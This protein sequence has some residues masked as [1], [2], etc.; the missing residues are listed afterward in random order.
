MASLTVLVGTR[1]VVVSWY[2]PYTFSSCCSFYLIFFFVPIH[3][4]L[5]VVHNRTRWLLVMKVLANKKLRQDVPKHR[6]FKHSLNG[7][8]NYSEKTAKKSGRL[9]AIRPGDT[10]IS[11]LNSSLHESEEYVQP[12]IEIFCCKERHGCP[13]QVLVLWFADA[14]HLYT[15]S[16]YKIFLIFFHGWIPWKEN[17]RKRWVSNQSRDFWHAKQSSWQFCTRRVSKE[18]SR[19]NSFSNIV[20]VSQGGFAPFLTIFLFQISILQ[21]F[22]LLFLRRAETGNETRTGIWIETGSQGTNFPRT[23]PLIRMKRKQT[24]AWSVALTNEPRFRKM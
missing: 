6:L 7:S 10:K 9:E 2:R 5:H 15:S 20:S 14:S 8:S 1:R 23:L 24:G 18:I 4:F 19:L 11:S 3:S 12:E 13:G 22:R 16:S 21:N 17:Q